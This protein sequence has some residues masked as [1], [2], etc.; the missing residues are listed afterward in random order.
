MQ[1]REQLT[2]AAQD[3]EGSL[4][5][6]RK[7]KEG[8]VFGFAVHPNDAPH[9]ILDASLGTRFK[10]VLFQIN[11]DET[12]VVPEEV[13]AGKKAV[14]MAGEMCRQKS[15]QDWIN[16]ETEL[17]EHLFAVEKGYGYEERLAASQLRDS[18]G[19]GS[20]SELAEDSQARDRFR[21]IIIKYRKETMDAG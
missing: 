4:M 17:G 1:N 6:M 13:R 2:D 19:I 9:G 14:A 11:D 8:W 16:S 18:L 20:R 21:D 7:A 12:F 15:F 10:C 5:I 3:F